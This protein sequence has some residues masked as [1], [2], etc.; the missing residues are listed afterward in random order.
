VKRGGIEGGWNVSKNRI[1]IAPKRERSTNDV[2]QF[3]W[4]KVSAGDGNV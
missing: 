3:A 4:Q 2:V 1:M